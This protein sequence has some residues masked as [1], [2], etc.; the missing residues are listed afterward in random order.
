MEE[1]E[2]EARGD[3]DGD[4]A[5][6]LPG[7][8]SLDPRHRRELYSLYTDA[9]VAAS[10]GGQQ[11]HK[12]GHRQQQQH[13]EQQHR[14]GGGGDGAA[15]AMARAAAAV[16]RMSSEALLAELPAALA[17]RVLL[18]DVAD[19]GPLGLSALKLLGLLLQSAAAAQQLPEDCCSELLRLLLCGMLPEAGKERA[20]LCMWLLQ[21]QQLSPGQL[22][23]RGGALLAGL[24]GC[25]PLAN[26]W[27][28]PLVSNQA[29]RAAARLLSQL[30]E[31]ALAAAGD[32][33][34]A[35]WP[36]MAAAPRAD[37]PAS[38]ADMYRQLRAEAVALT[39]QLA[40]A[41]RQAVARAKGQAAAGGGGG[42]GDGGG[43]GGADAGDN[44]AVAAAAVEAEMLARQLASQLAA[45]GLEELEGMVGWG[46]V[47]WV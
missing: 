27:G 12:S 26:N 11:Q 10:L 31:E 13:Q 37:A 3:G 41:V 20:K 43:E 23:G 25:M 46:G 6:A 34:P 18:H 14:D 38:R 5:A 21:T 44:K 32:W 24:R 45:G 2:A 30:P 29:V 15:A 39:A 33:G 1:D 9:F 4:A 40:E 8:S 28:S 42:G 17:W 35:L 19:A 7:L 22:A 36:L 47:Q 16:S